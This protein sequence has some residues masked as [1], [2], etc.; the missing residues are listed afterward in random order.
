V[1]TWDDYPQQHREALK[2]LK[3][4]ILQIKGIQPGKI[5]QTNEDVDYPAIPTMAK[6]QLATYLRTELLGS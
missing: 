5:V 4:I 2:A 3:E 6:R 1:D